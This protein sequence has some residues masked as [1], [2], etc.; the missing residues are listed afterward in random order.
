MDKEFTYKKCN[1]CIC[2]YIDQMLVDSL[3]V[4]YPYNYYSYSKNDKKNLVLKFK[5]FIDRLNLKKE[6]KS[7]VKP[8]ISVLDVGGG[9]GWLLDI[10]KKADN[11]V[12]DTEIVDL[13]VEAKFYAESKGHKYFLGSI[14]EFETTSKYDLILMLN[15][16]EHIQ[17]P[18]EIIL[19]LSSLLSLDGKILIKT[20]NV[21]SLD[22]RLFKNM[23]WGGLH[24]PRHWII[25][26]ESSFKKLIEKTDLEI[27][28]LKY[29]QGAPFWSWSF[30]IC[31]YK[32]RKIEINSK[33]PVM[34]HPLIPFLHIIFATF[35]FIRI[36]L[37][38]AKTSQMYI[39]LNKQNELE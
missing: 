35:D 14:D 18:K 6:L 11:R 20:P 38:Q 37:F 27:G 31:L 30:L 10:V 3:D 24:C 13:N 25:F 36:V 33:R 19:K 1:D 17:N 32:M 21:D 34:Y 22:A 9:S 29:T 15:L 8:K 2:I 26:S 4:I 7:I 12:V 16:I 23:Y 28:Y 5:E 39:L